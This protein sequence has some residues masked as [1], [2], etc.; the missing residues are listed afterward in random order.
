MKR[1]KFINEQQLD[2]LLNMY[3]DGREFNKKQLGLF[4]Y[5]E[6]NMYLGINNFKGDMKMED[7]DDKEKCIRFLKI[8]SI[9]NNKGGK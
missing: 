2:E 6:N 7:F 1:I 9:K 8:E 3:N 5:Q 4:I